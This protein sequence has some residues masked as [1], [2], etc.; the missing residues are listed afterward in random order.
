MRLKLL[1]FK[2]VFV[3]CCFFVSKS[4]AQEPYL[5]Q[6]TDEDGLPGMTIY[7]IFQDKQGYIWIGTDKGLCRYD[8]ETFQYFYNLNQ[9]GTSMTNLMQDGQGRLWCNNFS[10]QLFYAANDSLYEFTALSAQFKEEPIADFGI[11]CNNRLWYISARNIGYYHL[12]TKKQV[13]ID[14]QKYQQA[15]DDGLP[16]FQFLAIAGCKVITGPLDGI[17]IEI[18]ARGAIQQFS[19]PDCQYDATQDDCHHYHLLIPFEGNAQQCFFI[20]R[21]GNTGLAGHRYYYAKQKELKAFSALNEAGI[22]QPIGI[23]QDR[24]S[25]VWVYTYDG[26]Y[27][28]AEATK[29][30]NIGSYLR[31]KA[32]SKMIED[33]EGNYWFAT[34]KDGIYR[35]PQQ[36]VL[37][38]NATNSNLLDSRIIHIEKNNDNQLIVGYPGLRHSIL[39]AQN[40]K[41]VGV[42]QT[43]IERDH[44]SMAFNPFSKLLYLYQGI[45]M[46]LQSGQAK[47][48][49]S[50]SFMPNVKDFSF[51]DSTHV[52]VGSRIG[53]H[54]IRMDFKNIDPQLFA[55]LK[56][57]KDAFY[58]DYMQVVFSRYAKNIRCKAV[59]AESKQ[60]FWLGYVDTL[61]L[62]EQGAMQPIF[63]EEGQAIKSTNDITATEDGIIWVA[64]NNQGLFGFKDKDMIAHF[65]IA[66]GLVSNNVIALKAD[67]NQLYLGTDKGLQVLNAKDGLQKTFDKTDGF[68]S[69]EVN[70]IEVI[71]DFVFVA[72][73]KGLIRFHKEQAADNPYPPSILLG[74][75]SIGKRDTSLLESYQLAYH[76]NNLFVSFQGIAYR[77][78][79]RYHYKYRFQGL[80]EDWLYLPGG[81]QE[82]RFM[83]LAPGSYQ[84]E[85]YALNEDGV[86]SEMPIFINFHIAA[87]FWQ[88]WWF[89]L[90]IAI[91]VFL[92]IAWQFRMYR[93]RQ[94]L[95]LKMQQLRTQALQSQMNPHFIFNAMNAIQQLMM[96]DSIKNA[97]AYLARFAKL[98][99]TIF[100]ISGKPY[101]ELEQ[102][103]SFLRVYLDLEKLRFRDK[104]LIEFWIDPN[105]E[106]DMFNIP[107]LLIQPILENSFKHGLLH[108][109]DSGLL[110]L[111]FQKEHNFLYVSVEDNGI[112]RKKAV[113][114]SQWKEETKEK[115]GLTVTLSRLL[116]LAQHPQHAGNI[117]MTDLFDKDGRAIGLRTELWIPFEEKH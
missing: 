25:Q 55:R 61:M 3:L 53:A 43:M 72:T 2:Y 94:Q 88:S 14:I 32:V 45:L 31:G 110:S 34:L 69:N 95:V 84:L 92:L 67:A 65:S 78:Q 19:C 36:E 99:R 97:L 57:N 59:H 24:K 12:D 7:D 37:T 27:C 96:E 10:G 66:N 20:E 51:I 115:S 89:F 47:P 81:R 64:T 75:I 103:I 93:R 33:K 101:I 71:G 100:E 85:I 8:G 113:E 52:L 21:T 108:K 4:I 105:L 87:P 109:K 49:Y 11:D 80:S 6:L 83:G 86:A 29:A 5:T 22:K 44:E 41:Q 9:V 46:G 114:L 112:G 111:K 102:E 23:F 77:S 98:I 35:M 26:V 17:A 42:Y 73:N 74:K 62:F 38:L 70:D 117:R 28:S 58:P 15:C 107:P 39:D 18:D 116:L 50:S 91:A 104:V 48:L 106:K 60:R 82:L 68:C 56:L 54:L 63:N 79:G 16:L 76:Q 13:S 30:A 90:S 40:F 1:S